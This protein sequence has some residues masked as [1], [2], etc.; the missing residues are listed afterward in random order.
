MYSGDLTVKKTTTTRPYFGLCRPL[1]PAEPI[2]EDFCSVAGEIRFLD[3]AQGLLSGDAFAA[4]GLGQTGLPIPGG[5][6]PPSLSLGSPLPFCHGAPTLFPNNQPLLYSLSRLLST[7][8]PVN[9]E[10]IEV[11]QGKELDYEIRVR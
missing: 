1:P 6:P 10:N 2:C 7:F 3:C 4:S 11:N 8:L 9:G 5:Y